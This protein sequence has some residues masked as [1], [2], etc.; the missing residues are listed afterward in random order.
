MRNQLTKYTCGMGMVPSSLV[1]IHRLV[2]CIKLLKHE[3]EVSIP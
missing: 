3:G 1:E 2:A